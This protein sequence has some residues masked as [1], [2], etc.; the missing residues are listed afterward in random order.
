METH[1]ELLN[2]LKGADENLIKLLTILKD[3]IVQLKKENAVFKYFLKGMYN[4]P[5]EIYK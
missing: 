2:A 1:N 5:D 3:E 4:V